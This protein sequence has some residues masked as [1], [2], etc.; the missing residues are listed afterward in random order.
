MGVTKISQLVGN[1]RPQND[2]LPLKIVD[3]TDSETASLFKTLG[4]KTTLKIY[5]AIQDEPKTAP[6]LTDFSDTTI[7]NIHYHLNK[8]EDAGLIEPVDSWLSDSGVEMKVYGPVYSPLVISFAPSSDN[9]SI[10]SA[11]ENALHLIGVLSFVS[12]CVEYLVGFFVSEPAN[13]WRDAASSGYGA[14]MSIRD[15][16]LHYPGLCL[17]ATGFVVILGYVLFACSQTENSLYK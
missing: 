15:I 3:I 9:D 11:I 12:L 10:R 7:Q 14:G 13:P 2:D 1:N 17:F 16:L 5:S 8:L 6:E 4:D